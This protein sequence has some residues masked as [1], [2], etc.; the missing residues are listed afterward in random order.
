MLAVPLAVCAAADVAWRGVPRWMIAVV[1]VTALPH[2]SLAG[3]VA[4]LVYALFARWW[5]R[6]AGGDVGR[7]DVIMCVAVGLHVGW[8]IIVPA[9]AAFLLGA[10]VSFG[11][12][13]RLP[14]VPFLAAFVLV[15]A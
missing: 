13:V 15:L 5:I 9:S 1:A 10:M 12:R 3:A 8:L 7:G 11:L 2:P 6:Y 14:W 4:G